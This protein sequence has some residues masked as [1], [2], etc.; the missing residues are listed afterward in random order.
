MTRGRTCKRVGWTV[1]KQ[2]HFF[3]F[4]MFNRNA[5]DLK[6]KT[7]QRPNTSMLTEIYGSI[8][9]HKIQILILTKTLKLIQN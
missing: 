1:R 8:I 5:F 2:K 4:L 3:F 7:K 9:L 6:T